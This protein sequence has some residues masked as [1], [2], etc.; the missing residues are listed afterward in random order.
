MTISSKCLSRLRFNSDSSSSGTSS[1]LNVTD[2]LL[3]EPVVA[4]VPH[5]E[6]ASLRTASVSILVDH[7]TS[8]AN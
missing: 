7:Y 8:I 5:I 1:R 2:S 3:A 4:Y 6:S